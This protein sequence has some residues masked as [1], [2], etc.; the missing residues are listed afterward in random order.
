MAEDR[1][2]EAIAAGRRLLEAEGRPALSMKRIA[3]ALG[4]RSPSLY[5]HLADKAAVE[6]AL[7][8]EDLAELGDALHGAGGDLAGMAAAYRRYATG[9]PH[10][11]VLMTEQPLPRTE[12]PAGLEERVAAALLDA[13]GDEH[14][15]RAAWAAAHG[16]A[17]LE[18]HERFPPGADL[19][20][21]WAAMVAAFA[22]GGPPADG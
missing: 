11:Y 15:A 10:L 14:R 13:L 9:H 1:R 2:R 16:L 8:A 7:I 21:A 5:K 4:I 6:T 18:V 17:V 3:D 20:A 22:T 12:L 19:D